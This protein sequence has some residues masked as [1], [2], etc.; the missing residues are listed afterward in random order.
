MTS[1][2]VIFDAFLSKI[3]EDAWC[4]TEVNLIQ[5]TADWES[6]LESALPWFK[7]PKHSLARTGNVYHEDGTV[8]FGSFNDD[9][10]DREIQII[11]TLMK[12]RWLDRNVNSWQNV[13]VMYDE[14]DFSHANLLNNFIKLL[15][16]A[17]E[18]CWRLQKLYARSPE[19]ET[20]RRTAWKFSS[21]AGKNRGK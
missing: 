21:L 4:G 16:E 12:W 8:D 15:Q 2:K 3:R 10:D 5:I 1:Y 18:E 7:F 19:D 9:L 20:G 6:I 11:A 17:Q 14:R 13:K